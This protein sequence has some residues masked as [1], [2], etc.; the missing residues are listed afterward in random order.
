M[1]SKTKVS[2]PKTPRQSGA[3]ASA[4]KPSG[5]IVLYTAPDGT[6]SLDVKLERETVWLNQKQMALL[7]DKDADTIGLHIRNA[8]KEGELEE[9]ATTEDSSVV[10]NEGSRTVRR[11]VRFYN[12]DVVISVGYR[13]K[14]K[15]GTQFR[16]WATRVLRDHLLQGYTVNERRLRDLN[17]A[18]R[19]IAAAAD[20]RDLSGDEAKAL[21]QVV[22]E[23]RFALDLLDDYDYQRV[24]LPPAGEKAVYSLSYPEACGSWN[25]Y[26]SDSAVRPCSGGKRTRGCRPP[27]AQSCR[28][29]GERISTR[30]WKRRPRT[31]SISSS[32]TTPL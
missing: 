25:N 27:W 5:E 20:R 15:R 19:L 18:V 22:G 32:R 21:L 12:L 31:C 29:S 17:Q 28:P 7:F 4:V 8:Y 9:T 14:S 10:Q 2:N 23:Y 11:P 1:P 6:T 26:G 30:A 16:I 3:A 24:G 13:V